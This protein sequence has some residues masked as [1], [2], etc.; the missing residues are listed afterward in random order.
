[1]EHA[2][3]KK[4]ALLPQTSGEETRH[5]WAS[6]HFLTHRQ[7]ASKG[8]RWLQQQKPTA[9]SSENH[10][11]LWNGGQIKM[12]QSHVTQ[13]IQ[14]K[15]PSLLSGFPT[16]WGW[17]VRF[18]KLKPSQNAPSANEEAFC[19]SRESKE[20]PAFSFFYLNLYQKTSAKDQGLYLKV[21][22]KLVTINFAIYFV[23]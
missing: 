15:R 4:T 19:T 6:Q 23:Y 21:N 16:Q 12:F 7:R 2:S 8:S 10:I 13:Q 20:H 17:I 18:V 11:L 9:I 22:P 5:T 1:M 3:Q 14:R